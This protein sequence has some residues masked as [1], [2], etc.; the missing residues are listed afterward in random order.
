MSLPVTCAVVNLMT[1]F[2]RFNLSVSMCQ[3]NCYNSDN[4]VGCRT[5]GA[6]DC[7]HLQHNGIRVDSCLNAK[8]W[9]WDPV[10]KKQCSRKSTDS[11]LSFSQLLATHIRL[12]P[13]YSIT[14]P[15]FPDCR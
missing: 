7:A 1:S 10:C 13:S 15:S 3:F 8:F 5:E 9:H 11:P 2:P 4:Q 6:S 14:L 12:P